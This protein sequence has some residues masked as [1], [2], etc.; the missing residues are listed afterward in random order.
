MTS[1]AGPAGPPS[2][3][4]AAWGLGLIVL[5]LCALP[6]LAG[7]AAGA[8]MVVAGGAQRSAGGAAAENGRHAARWGATYL[9]VALLSGLAFL[10]AV[11]LAPDG[12]AEPSSSLLVAPL[13]VYGVATLV[14]LGVIARG[15]EAARHGRAF[16]V[17]GTLPL[18]R[19]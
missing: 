4:A 10:A 17:P 12:G 5:P 8:A 18:F 13:V 11:L 14:H 7:V 19:S 3:G 6:F 2:G 15:W 1:T 9:I 16:R